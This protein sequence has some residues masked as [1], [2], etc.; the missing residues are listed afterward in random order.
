MPDAV[1][2]WF[3]P[4]AKP[5][6]RRIW[7]LIGTAATAYDCLALMGGSGDYLMLPNGERP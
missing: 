3:R 5:G 7:K 1:A 2:L 6:T 4:P